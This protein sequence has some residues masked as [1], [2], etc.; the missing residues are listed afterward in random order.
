VDMLTYSFA[1]SLTSGFCEI[2]KGMFF[3]YS[4]LQ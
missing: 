4:N 3:V 2:A 1:T